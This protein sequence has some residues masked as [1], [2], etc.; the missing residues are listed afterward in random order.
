M[1]IIGTRIKK[2]REEKGIKQEYIAHEMEI[3]QGNYSRLEKDDSRLN[4]PKLQ[5]IV[6]I[7]NISFSSLFDE[8]NSFY[9]ENNEEQK[10]FVINKEYI[11]SLKEEIIFLRKMLENKK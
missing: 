7:L 3:S 2:I 1:N 6:K 9:S 4:V 8:G 11:Q 10:R 5:K